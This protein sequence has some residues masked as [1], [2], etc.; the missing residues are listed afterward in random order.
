MVTWFHKELGL[1]L[2]YDILC[3]SNCR[4]SGSDGPDI[5]PEFQW[6]KHDGTDML[7]TGAITITAGFA[8]PL[9]SQVSSRLC[10]AE[11]SAYSDFSYYSILRQPWSTIFSLLVL[12]LVQIPAGVGLIL[13]IVGATSANSPAEIDDEGS[14]KVGVILFTV[15][16]ALLCL[17]CAFASIVARRTKRGERSIIIAVAFALPFLLVRVIYSLIAA[18][19]HNIDF[20]PGYGS[21]AAITISLFMEVLEECAVVLL[22]LAVGLKLPAVPIADAATGEKL[23]YRFGRGDFTGGKLG[24][25]SLGAAVISGGI[26]KSKSSRDKHAPQQDVARGRASTQQWA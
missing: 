22:Y 13:C 23:A 20:Q 26:K 21:T 15:A 7:C 8:R 4:F 1:D 12:R 3:G 5:E 17:L 11:G 18:F 24:L 10:S 19:S 14:V 16:Y 9:G 2:S 25:L 6:S